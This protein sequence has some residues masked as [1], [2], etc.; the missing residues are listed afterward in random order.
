MAETSEQIR[1]DLER[2]RARVGGTIAAL[3]RKVNPRYMLDDHP[4]AMV[5]AAFGVGVL[6][7]ATGAAQK[8]AVGAAHEVRD[9][10]QS[11]AD[12]ASRTTGDVV[13]RIVQ[14][15]VSTARS[16]I[17]AKLTEAMANVFPSPGAT[18]V[19]PR[20]AH[21]PTRYLGTET[22]QH[23]ASDGARSDFRAA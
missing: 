7:G 20:P 16:A 21:A 6:L 11:G 23:G 19:Q 3:E 22:Q 8:A 15:V 13:D 9:Q 12:Q 1:R 10:I 18:S 14:T 17:T 2:T 5:G 4:V